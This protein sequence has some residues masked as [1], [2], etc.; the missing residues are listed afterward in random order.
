VGEIAMY[1]DFFLETAI[2]YIL[3]LINNTS[4]NGIKSTV[5]YPGRKS[6]I[7]T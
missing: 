4:V 5:E 7:S 2:G 6:G 1:L 3:F